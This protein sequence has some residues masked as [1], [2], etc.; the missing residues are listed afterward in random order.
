MPPE[1]CVHVEADGVLRSADRA[2]LLELLRETEIL[3]FAVRTV[4]HVRHPPGR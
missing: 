3:R 4:E 2:R 1:K